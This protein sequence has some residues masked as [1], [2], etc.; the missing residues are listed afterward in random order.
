[1]INVRETF[2]P[3]KPW[4]NGCFSYHRNNRE[5]APLA[6]ETNAS[7]TSLLERLDHSPDLTPSI[8]NNG[9]LLFANALM[10]Y[11][12]AQGFDPSAKA[13]PWLAIGMPIT[14]AIY[15]GI[16]SSNTATSSPEDN[17]NLANNSIC[18]LAM[19]GASYGLG[20]LCGYLTR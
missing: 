16:R 19:A 14:A 2:Q 20:Y 13:V 3:I 12:H 11:F 7:Q 5:T 8:L 9:T 6:G 10:G 17:R 18:G 4:L 15:G 1:M